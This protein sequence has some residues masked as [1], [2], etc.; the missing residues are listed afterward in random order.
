MIEYMVGVV[1]GA[2]GL[3]TLLVIESRMLD[4]DKKTTLS[5]RGYSS[6]ID[7]YECEKCGCVVY[8]YSDYCASC[9]RKVN[10]E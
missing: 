9:G 8:G 6:G 5:D 1:V 2:V 10:Y 7:A 3:K 4:R